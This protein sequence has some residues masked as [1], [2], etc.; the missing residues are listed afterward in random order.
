MDWERKLDLV[1]VRLGL[2]RVA[3]FLTW[4]ICR[5]N[6]GFARL[7]GLHGVLDMSILCLTVHGSTIR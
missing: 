4:L 3:P 5:N 2:H 1:R 6:L 7:C